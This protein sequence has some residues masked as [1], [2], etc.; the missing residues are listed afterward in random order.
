MSALQIKPEHGFWDTTHYPIGGNFRRAGVDG[1]A[2]AKH[3]RD[4]KPACRGC[5]LEVELADGSKAATRYAHLEVD[6]Y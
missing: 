1:A 5:D 3:L 4:I 6:G 2:I